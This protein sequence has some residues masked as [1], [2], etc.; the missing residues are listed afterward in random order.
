MRR[1]ESRRSQTSCFERLQDVASWRRRAA[2]RSL[3]PGRDLHHPGRGRVPCA[4]HTGRRR[5]HGLQEVH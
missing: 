3:L 5:F 1:H 2:V 4:G